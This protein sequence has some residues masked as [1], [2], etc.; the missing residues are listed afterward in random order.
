LASALACSAAS[1]TT[2]PL[3]F[4]IEF[5]K[6]IKRLE[7]GP[8]GGFLGSSVVAFFLVSVQSLLGCSVEDEG[9]SGLAAFCP[10]RSRWSTRWGHSSPWSPGLAAHR[11]L[12]TSQ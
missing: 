1:S 8:T 10:R 9:L 11:A 7:I 6:S 5:R 2:E 12:G 4:H 3:A